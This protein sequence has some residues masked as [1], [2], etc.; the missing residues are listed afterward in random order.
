MEKAGVMVLGDKETFIIRVL[1]KKINDAGIKA[2]F[3]PAGINDVNRKW[4]EFNILTYYLETQET[5]PDEIAFYL[6]DKLKDDDKKIILIGEPDDTAKLS[7]SLGKDVIYKV[8]SRPLDNRSYMDTVSDFM[9]KA[10]EGDF[11]KS[12]LIVDDDPSYLTLIREW[13]KD[14]YKVNMAS[15]GLQAIRW[16]AKNRAD[17]ILLDHEMPVTSGPK[18]LEMLR[19]DDETKDI[20]VIFLTGKGDKASVMQVVAL[21]P[22][23]YFL[24]TVK[25]DELLG[26]LKEFFELRKTE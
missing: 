17:L 9:S 12:I 23:G 24:K 18:V 1:V 14:S 16:L 21:K 15:S 6:R 11:L 22:E 2:E 7:S 19:S 8:F 20:P 4:N 25:K 26:K 10:R 5:V 3:V 13:L